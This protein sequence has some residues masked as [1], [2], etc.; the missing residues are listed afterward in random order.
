MV[1]LMKKQQGIT[2]IVALILLL[3]MSLIGISTMSSS[4]MQK[5]IA[6][7]QQRKAIARLNA[8]SALRQAENFLEI[9]YKKPSEQEILLDF[10]APNYPYLYVSQNDSDALANLAQS[11]TW[12]NMGRSIANSNGNS[13]A[14]YVIE[15]IG[16]METT[17]SGQADIGVE[18]KDTVT[19]NPFVFRVTAIGYASNDISAVLQSTYATGQGP[20]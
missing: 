4:N 18:Q 9:N 6:G 14:K 10:S 16:R 11:A 15:Y 1:L 20:P 19:Q 8:E 17:L 7:N 5:N 13:K 12:S 3:I 2:L